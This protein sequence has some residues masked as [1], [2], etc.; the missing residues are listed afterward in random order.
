MKIDRR[1]FLRGGSGIIVVAVA[2]GAG[3]YY[4]QKRDRYGSVPQYETR[5]STSNS[6]SYVMT[7]SE[8]TVERD[9][10][11]I[12]ILGG[13]EIRSDCMGCS[14][15]PQ[16]RT[17]N[18][19]RLA[20]EGIR[21]T[22]AFT[23]S[24]LCMPA[25][26][27]FAN[28]LYPHDHGVWMNDSPTIPPG[29]NDVRRMPPDDETFYHHLQKMGYLT[30][31]IGKAH[32]YHTA[33]GHVKDEE[34]YMHA[35]GFEYVHETT[36]SGCMRLQC[37]MKDD[38]KRKGLLELYRED[39]LERRRL[40]RWAVRPS[41]L[42]VEDFPDSYVGWKAVEFVKEY[43]SE[44]PMCLS[45]GFPGPWHFWDAPGEYATMYEPEKTPP[46]MEAGEPGEWVPQKA[47]D[48]MLFRRLEKM[49]LEDVNEVRANYYGEISLIDYWIGQ[50]LDAFEDR[51]WLD[52]LL[53]IFWSDH[54]DMLGDHKRLGKSVFYE[55]SIRVPLII[56]WPGRIDSGKSDALVETVDVSP[57]ILEAVGASPSERCLGRS[58]WPIMRDPAEAHRK[59]VLSEVYFHDRRR[60]MIRTRDYK[61]AMTDAGEGYLLH[62]LDEDPAERENLIGR[63]D[64]KDNEMKLQDE[65]LELK[66]R[67]G[68]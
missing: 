35:R 17:P 48:T 38:L 67:F 21:F 47:L 32:F 46:P 16:I 13:E 15:H 63:P 43:E 64:E 5:P 40:P 59:A 23:V 12:L 42:P 68:S 2:V 56:R 26:A 53:V 49:S 31:H 1:R 50:I 4:F 61:Y 62:D 52:D 41:P 10:P 66:L 6:K 57:T 18:L 65:L 37:H 60:L 30:A 3:Y 34:E 11:N 36:F 7:S 29:V 8:S 33:G 54:G 45:I 39:C 51:G 58:L 44:R 9:K 27:S 25:R 14:G 55:S 28:G 19:D 22:N 24:P 20:A